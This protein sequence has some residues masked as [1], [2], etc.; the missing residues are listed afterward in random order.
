MLIVELVWP[1]ILLQW[2]PKSVG[3][4]AAASRTLFQ[5]HPFCFRTVSVASCLW[6]LWCL[7]A[8]WQTQLWCGQLQPWHML[9][10]QTGLHSRCLI[11][12]NMIYMINTNKM[13][14]LSTVYCLPKC[15][16]LSVY[17]IDVNNKKNNI[18][19]LML[20][21]VKTLY[22]YT[23]MAARL[24]PLTFTLLFPLSLS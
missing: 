3:S 24:C 4:S 13:A 8:V 6:C 9:V 18:C 23:Y 7:F 15:I 21:A 19:P 5:P 14:I 20:M 22:S 17:R 12:V 2:S 10:P 1:Q 16:S 11:D